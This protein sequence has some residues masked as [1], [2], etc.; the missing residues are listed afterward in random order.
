[1]TK[2]QCCEI[3]IQ[4]TQQRSVCSEC[5]LKAKK[6]QDIVILN[7]VLA[8][9]NEYRQNSS[10]RKI[11]IACMKHFDDQEVIDAKSIL[12]DHAGNV[13]G[14]MQNRVDS[15]LRSTPG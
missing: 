7:N 12:Y 15:N 11:Q 14:P 10:S 3:D 9:I 6:G 2:C 5:L 4:R 13:L 8:Y 1:M